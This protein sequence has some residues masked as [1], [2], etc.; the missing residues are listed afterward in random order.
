MPVTLLITDVDRFKLF[1]DTHG[2]QAGD[3][4]LRG[5]SR[6]MQNSV[7]AKDIVARSGG[8]EFAIIFPGTTVEQARTLAEHVRSKIEAATF[9]FEG[10]ELR[11]TCSVGLAQL[12]EG[13]S[14]DE[15]VQWADEALY[16]SKESGR[17]CG[18]WHD[19]TL[20][21]PIVDPTP[22][23]T[24]TAPVQESAAHDCRTTVDG[25]GRPG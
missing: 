3:E 24:A 6:T 22:A 2:H 10:T 1:N 20:I 13:E 17:N 7:R 9:D 16:G 14:A 4:V 5:V 11:V 25:C 15:C 19:G 18:H 23:E 12:R 8:E 21:R